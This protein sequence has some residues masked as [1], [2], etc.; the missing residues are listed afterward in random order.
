[1][2]SG[3]VD[4]V[5]RGPARALVSAPENGPYT[6][7]V[8]FVRSMLDRVG[9]PWRVLVKELSAFGVVGLIN[10]FVDIGLFNALHF[11]AGIG[12]LTAKVISTSISTT[13]AYFLNRHWS[14]SHR[15]RIGLARE[16]TL[17]FVLNAVALAMGLVVIGLTRYGFDLTDKVSLNVANLVG[18]GFGTIFRFWSY[19]RWVFPPHVSAAGSEPAERAAA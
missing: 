5:M 1:L 10:L 3:Y 2:V 19:K 17:F 15:A 4:G 7:P 18:I 16:Y 6:P 13:S 12:P 9:T 14:F 8:S 11:G